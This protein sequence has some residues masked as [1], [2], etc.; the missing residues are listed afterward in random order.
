MNSDCD[1]NFK[2]S[3]RYHH[4]ESCT[5]LNY[6]YTSRQCDEYLD[7]LEELRRIIFGQNY[8]SIMSSGTVFAP[9][10]D[11]I[12]YHTQN[13]RTLVYQIK[14][15]SDYGITLSPIPSETETMITETFCAEEHVLNQRETS[16]IIFPNL[17]HQIPSTIEERMQNCLHSSS[18][19]INSYFSDS[20]ELLNS[21][22]LNYTDNVSQLI[23]YSQSEK[24]QMD[25]YHHEYSDYHDFKDVENLSEG[26][27]ES[28]AVSGEFASV[29]E[30]TD[31]VFE[32]LTDESF[33][34]SCTISDDKVKRIVGIVKRHGVCTE[35]EE[36][37]HVEENPDLGVYIPLELTGGSR[38][39]TPNDRFS[40]HFSSNETDYTK[41]CEVFD[42]YVFQ[43][44]SIF[45]TRSSSSTG[46][47]KQLQLPTDDTN[48]SEN[49]PAVAHNSRQS[50]SVTQNPSGESETN[51]TSENTSTIIE[52]ENAGNSILVNMIQDYVKMV[53]DASKELNQSNRSETFQDN[54]SSSS[55]P[56][57]A[58]VLGVGQIELMKE[59]ETIIETLHEKTDKTEIGNK[60]IEFLNGERV[61][62][63]DANEIVPNDTVPSLMEHSV[64]NVDLS[65]RFPKTEELATIEN[66]DNQTL[67]DIVFLPIAPRKSSVEKWES[68][69]LK[70]EMQ[71]NEHLFSTST[72]PVNYVDNKLEFPDLTRTVDCTENQ[73]GHIIEQE[74][75]N[76]DKS[77]TRNDFPPQK[78]EKSTSDQVFGTE[79][80][81][82][83]PKLKQ[84]S[85]VP[86]SDVSSKLSVSSLVYFF[87]NLAEATSNQQVPKKIKKESIS[88]DFDNLSGSRNSLHPQ[89]KERAEEQ[90]HLQASD[91]GILHVE[92][93]QTP[94]K[95]LLP[96][97]CN[98]AST[99]SLASNSNL[100][101]TQ[102]EIAEENFKEQSTQNLPFPNQV[103]TLM[104]DSCRNRQH[105]KEK[106]GM[107]QEPENVTIEPSCLSPNSLNP[108]WCLQ[109]SLINEIDNRIT[110]TD[111]NVLESEECQKST[112]LVEH[113]H[114]DNDTHLPTEEADSS[115][116][117]KN[118]IS[119]NNFSETVIPME[120][121]TSFDEGV[122]GTIEA[123]I[124]SVCRDSLEAISEQEPTYLIVPVYCDYNCSVDVEVE[125]TEIKGELIADVD[126]QENSK[127]F[128]QEEVDQMNYGTLT[129]IVGEQTENRSENNK[130][131]ESEKKLQTP[132]D[133]DPKPQ[134]SSLEYATLKFNGDA[135]MNGEDK[136]IAGTTKPSVQFDS[137]EKVFPEVDEYEGTC[138][139]L[140]V[141]TSENGIV[142]TT[143]NFDEYGSTD[144]TPSTVNV[145]SFSSFDQEQEIAEI[146][147]YMVDTVSASCS[148]WTS[149]ESN[150]V[151]SLFTESSRTRAESSDEL[152]TILKTA[153]DEIKEVV[154]NLLEILSSS[155]LPEDND[156]SENEFEVAGKSSNHSVNNLIQS[157]SSDTVGD[158]LPLFIPSVVDVQV[159]VK[160]EISDL[161][162]NMMDIVSDDCFS[163]LASENSSFDSKIVEPSKIHSVT[164][165]TQFSNSSN[166]EVQEISDLV[167]ELTILVSSLNTE[168]NLTTYDDDHD[169]LQNSDLENFEIETMSEELDT[170]IG[171]LLDIVCSFSVFQEQAES[172]SDADVVDIQIEPH[173]EPLEEPE[174]VSVQFDV[175]GISDVNGSYLSFD[176]DQELLSEDDV[177]DV[178]DCSPGTHI[179]KSH[180]TLN[181][182]TETVSFENF[183]NTSDTSENDQTISDPSDNDPE[184]V[185]DVI[186]SL[187]ETIDHSENN[188]VFNDMAPD[189]HSSNIHE[190]T[191]NLDDS[192]H[193]E[194]GK[195]VNES[196]EDSNSDVV[197]VVGMLLDRVE[198]SEKQYKSSENIIDGNETSFSN[199]YV[200]TT[201]TP[202]FEND[203]VAPS[204]QNGFQN[205]TETS[206]MVAL[207]ASTE[208]FSSVIDS[209]SGNDNEIDRDVF[210]VVN[211][212]LSAFNST[213][214]QIDNA[215]NDAINKQEQE[216]LTEES[217]QQLNETEVKTSSELEEDVIQVVDDLLRAVTNS[218]FCEHQTISSSNGSKNLENSLL[219]Q[220]KIEKTELLTTNPEVVEVIEYMVDIVSD[221][222]DS[223]T[224][225][226]LAHKEM[227]TVRCVLHEMLNSVENEC[228]MVGTDCDLDDDRCI[229]EMVE[230]LL[231]DLDRVV[232]VGNNEFHDEYQNVV[233]K[234]SDIGNQDY[235][236]DVKKTKERDIECGEETS[237]INEE[238]PVTVEKEKEDADEHFTTNESFS[239]NDLQNQLLET[240]CKKIER[241]LEGH[242]NVGGEETS[243]WQLTE[244]EQADS[245]NM[246]SEDCPNCDFAAL[247]DGCLENLVLNQTSIAMTDAVNF[248]FSD[249]V[250]KIDSENLDE[251]LD[252][253]GFD[254][255]IQ[256]R[257]SGSDE[258]DTYCELR[259]CEKEAGEE[260]FSID[261]LHDTSHITDSEEFLRIMEDV[262]PKPP[263]VLCSDIPLQ[264]IDDVKHDIKGE[265]LFDQQYAPF[266]FY[267]AETYPDVSVLSECSQVSASP[268]IERTATSEQ[269]SSEFTPIVQNFKIDNLHDLDDN[270]NIES[271]V[272]KC[273]IIEDNDPKP[274]SICESIPSLSQTLLSELSKVSHNTTILDY[275]Q[276]NV[277]E[278]ICDVYA[279]TPTDI[280]TS[281]RTLMNE[282]LE[283]E[284]DDETAENRIE[285]LNLLDSCQQSTSESTQ[286]QVVIQLNPPSSASINRFDFNVTAESSDCS[287]CTDMYDTVPTNTSLK[288]LTETSSTESSLK[289]LEQPSTSSVLEEVSHFFATAC[290]AALAYMS[291]SESSTSSFNGDI[292]EDASKYISNTPEHRNE[293]DK[294]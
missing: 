80:S 69:T 75:S 48:L 20:K 283:E 177:V 26:I 25:Y 105:E 166:A 270:Q 178:I 53:M 226:D 118:G 11:S 77:C 67:A 279:K 76:F 291:Q 164:C 33:D 16:K 163:Q 243:N 212:L 206:D 91:P 252:V 41:N 133:D 160:E 32:E 234:P 187:L 145:E 85:T 84:S 254:S 19:A 194:T 60:R 218:S 171:S 286:H 199:S 57:N 238:L 248:Y 174:I 37:E 150:S 228:W 152:P 161:V 5:K 156:S 43:L 269:L 148:I 71:E 62:S 70:S 282:I 90:I 92:I 288:L 264:L 179:E 68:A 169:R 192:C 173:E 181:E 99:D 227:D 180:Q 124:A 115:S 217:I 196:V 197:E 12:Q 95:P 126:D 172:N 219:L 195:P 134:L 49:Q 204:F 131:S 51:E 285:D 42:S 102:P 87:E 55:S 52:S 277:D 185:V 272:S 116:S 147:E 65:E 23:S 143:S 215:T 167:D 136:N 130:S 231:D 101:D 54:V 276:I 9:N 10:P 159:P 79:L 35:P 244:R 122:F 170:V 146:V 2:S 141:N 74:L 208:F 240:N 110:S 106:V 27:D 186:L 266:D 262:I 120:S 157:I 18:E 249:L 149:I 273:N 237:G 50:I 138:S 14:D 216:Y 198:V 117:L 271:S 176:D 46:H 233:P 39:P 123:L 121:A 89:Q 190:I 257:K 135:S 158:C 182:M 140:E 38:T 82:S 127:K 290:V 73:D 56:F 30:E 210:E 245:R 24:G 203:S 247:I 114:G 239:C 256:E 45:N 230:R 103:E 193:L 200:N 63:M 61:E 66:N 225:N 94:A 222:Q 78:K 142:I 183:E 188:E 165:F 86:S 58:C 97:S 275:H 8:R 289:S 47:E 246:S 205:D 229:S 88:N 292:I 22:K 287:L 128:E 214:G 221:Y 267:S 59:K 139:K 251:C 236:K 81:F 189:S 83:F 211:T 259:D 175:I 6:V 209:T 293:E 34:D 223:I 17:C 100:I 44:P 294:I 3:S 274:S 162:N 98:T 241:K 235:E 107:N 281:P 36:W 109:E 93:E 112:C 119:N 202:V 21:A 151:D 201:P 144:L 104:I 213:F 261:G 15:P 4:S 184:M 132:L 258:F 242:S 253:P 207:I 280:C 191:N 255:Q 224:T 263:D 284:K 268:D 31:S 154:D 125:K 129:P 153:T 232:T 220:N 113:T 265:K 13:G 40:E 111:K 29:L 250:T 108:D 28:F 168:E 7:Y 278:K 96:S 260:P 155:V 64:I 1:D 72:Q 137:L